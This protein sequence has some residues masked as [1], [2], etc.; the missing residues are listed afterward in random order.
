MRRERE[1]EWK[2]WDPLDEASLWSAYSRMVGLREDLPSDNILHWP[3]DKGI[4]MGVLWANGM[5]RAY[6]KQ[7]R[8]D[9]REF[10]DWTR[11]E[12]ETLD[13]GLRDLCIEEAYGYYGILTQR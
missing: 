7:L 9:V 2:E 10:H 5:M 4:E 3:S 12:R 13:H 1:H 11:T 8:R 6:R